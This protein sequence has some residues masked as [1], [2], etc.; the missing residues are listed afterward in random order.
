MIIHLVCLGRIG[1]S[2][3]VKWGKVGWAKEH[4]T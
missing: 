4:G 1:L 2:W 3:F